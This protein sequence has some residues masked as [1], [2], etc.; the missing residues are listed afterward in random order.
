MSPRGR[1]V[2]SKDLEK[3]MMGTVLSQLLVT[4]S[5]RPHLVSEAEIK[6]G[7]EDRSKGVTSRR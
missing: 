3:N 4:I 2:T 7:V 6:E 5:N 1:T